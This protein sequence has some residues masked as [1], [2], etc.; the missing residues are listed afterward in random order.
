MRRMTLVLACSVLPAL[1]GCTYYVPAGAPVPGYSTPSSFDRS[2][3]AASGAMRDQGL[4][5][6]VEDRASGTI[7]GKAGDGSLTA[8]VRTQADGSV[9]VQFNTTGAVDPGLIER[10]SRSYDRHMGR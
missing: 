2:F 9:R 4:A 7:V 10:V 5:I 1:W 8:A 6:S 3:A